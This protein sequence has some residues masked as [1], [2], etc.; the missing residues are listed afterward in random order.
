MGGDVTDTASGDREGR[1][2]GPQVVQSSCRG[3]EVGPRAGQGSKPLLLQLPRAEAH[4][5]GPHG[6][7]G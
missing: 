6:D 5:Q 1:P 3:S 2:V 4:H 7:R